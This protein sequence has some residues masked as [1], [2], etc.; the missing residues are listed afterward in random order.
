MDN[1]YILSQ[2]TNENEIAVFKSMRTDMATAKALL[3]E[4]QFAQFMQ[5]ATINQTILND[6]SFRRMNSTSQV[7]SSTKITGRVL[8]NGYKT[9]TTKNDT[10]N[11][12]LT[13]ADVDFG[14]AELVATKLK[15]LTSILDDDKEDNIEREQFEQTLLSMMGE[16]VGVDL[17]A[18][19]VFGDTT[20]KSSGN[21]DPLFSCIDGWLTSATTTLKSDGAKGSGTKDFDLADGITAMFD[22]ML[23]SMP[24][25][26]RQA[27]LMKDLVFYVPYEVQEAYREFLIDR[28]TGLGDSSLL[29]AEE[30]KYKGI[31]V[32]YAP[33]LDAVDGRTV[34]GN[35]ASILTVP[36]FLWY[37]VYK[38]LSVEPH[39]DVAN[40]KTD[41]YYR[42]RCDAANQWTDAVIAAQI[43]AAEAA[44]L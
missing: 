19:C 5:A 8:Q 30:L 1:Q 26:Y 2:L 28:E 13:P 36:E 43:T 29:N 35:V 27:N 18:V 40:E 22:K 15:A 11:D 12:N 9:V 38:D 17:E 39:R 31:P 23:Y 44:A 21:P 25:A 14:K 33:V 16:A 3:N 24:A 32:K 7:V 37:G 41:Y 6:A 42:I 20:Y 34:H 10:T 4:E